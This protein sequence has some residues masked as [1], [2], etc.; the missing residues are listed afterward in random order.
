MVLLLR[1]RQYFPECLLHMP[2]IVGS[3]MRRGGGWERVWIC[4]LGRFVCFE[5]GSISPR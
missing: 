2:F 5:Y 3:G 1:K 4:Q